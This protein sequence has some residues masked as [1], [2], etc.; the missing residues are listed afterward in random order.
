MVLTST[1]LVSFCPIMAD[2]HSMHKLVCHRAT[3][4]IQVLLGDPHAKSEP[5]LIEHDRTGTYLM[6]SI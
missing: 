3:S 1:V 4:F 2:A 5:V 6:V